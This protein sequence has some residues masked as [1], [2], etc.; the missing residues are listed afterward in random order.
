MYVKIRGATCFL[1]GVEPELGLHEPR[2]SIAREKV[3]TSRRGRKD[4]AVPQMVTLEKRP[5][6]AMELVCLKILPSLTIGEG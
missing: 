3:M 4:V 1:F 6:R 2:R 5:E